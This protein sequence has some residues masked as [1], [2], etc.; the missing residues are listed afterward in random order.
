M[1]NP[2]NEKIRI[3]KKRFD[4]LDKIFD[5][6][7][8]IRNK[9]YWL[10]DFKYS[11]IE[12]AN[13]SINSEFYTIDLDNIKDKVNETFDIELYSLH[14]NEE[15]LFDT[16]QK[17]YSLLLELYKKEMGKFYKLLF[18]HSMIIYDIERDIINEYEY[19]LEPDPFTNGA[20]YFDLQLKNAYKFV[21]EDILYNKY[22]KKV[23]GLIH[24]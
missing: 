21:N 6:L 11:I 17:I 2:C 1:N 14:N 8:K 24:C 10:Q 16:L 3:N 13:G 23:N 5:I 15:I 18:D 4:I 19:P 7:R 20:E 9:I 12:Y 22:K